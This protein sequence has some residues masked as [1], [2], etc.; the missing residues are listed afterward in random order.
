MVKPQPRS[1][2][3]AATHDSSQSLIDLSE[4]TSTAAPAC[5]NDLSGLSLSSAGGHATER[6]S[7][8]F[9]VSSSTLPKKSPH[10]S[11]SIPV[12]TTRLVPEPKDHIG[13]ENSAIRLQKQGA[14]VAVTE[15]L[16][17]K[18]N[19]TAKDDGIGNEHQ[20]DFDDYDYD[21][22]EVSSEF[23]ELSM[24]EPLPM[25]DFDYGLM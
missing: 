24:V 15:V 1:R 20:D 12:I 16:V 17:L 7:S 4:P 18:G 9:D 21:A 5:N 10:E 19:D 6:P 23:G 2:P 11:K 8:N 14:D 22:E 3:V 25:D 13:T